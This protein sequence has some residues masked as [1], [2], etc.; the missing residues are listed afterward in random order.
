MPAA[1]H[2]CDDDQSGECVHAT[3]KG[4]V[5]LNAESGMGSTKR[6]RTYPRNPEGQ[7]DCSISGDD[8]EDCHLYVS[9]RQDIAINEHILSAK[10][11]K[12]DCFAGSIKLSRYQRSQDRIPQR[13][14]TYTRTSMMHRRNRETA[15]HHIS[16]KRSEVDTVW[17]WV[18]ILNTEG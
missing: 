1:K 17:Q 3:G 15:S 5:D 13:V 16:V 6:T 8:F 2:D 11:L 4:V 10:M 14:L 9:N 18:E 7:P 12:Y